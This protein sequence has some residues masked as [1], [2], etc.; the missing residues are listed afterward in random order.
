MNIRL[1]AEK[2]NRELSSAGFPQNMAE[3]SRAF[4]KTFKISTYQANA[5]LLGQMKP[6]ESLLEA[7][8]REFETTPERLLGVTAKA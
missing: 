1:F 4:G 6:S 7:V 5:V 3:R 8:A 2:L